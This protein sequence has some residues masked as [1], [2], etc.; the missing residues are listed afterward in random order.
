MGHFV[1]SEGNDLRVQLHGNLG[2]WRGTARTIRE[3]DRLVKEGKV[4]PTVIFLAQQLARKRDKRDYLGQLKEFFNWIRKNIHY[5]RDPR[6]VEFVRSPFYTIYYRAG[7]CDD[8]AILFNAL[9]ESI[10]FKT[11][12]KTIKANAANTKEFSHVYGQACVPNHGW[13]SADTIVDRATLGWEA[14]ERFGSHVWEDGL[15]MLG[16]TA[17]VA[18]P[19]FWAQL[20]GVLGNVVVAS[21]NVLGQQAVVSLTDSISSPAAVPVAAIPSA[22][23]S[24]VM[25]AG[26]GIPGWLL[27]VGLVGAAVSLGGYMFSKRRR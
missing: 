22:A 10:G 19:G 6:D 15:G 7:D 27:P 9:A 11:R 4:D 16:E 14:P 5:V 1:N 24:G 26:I 25:T 23:P 17:T 18:K 2:G 8:Q 13:V 3:M 20:G 12:F 21:A